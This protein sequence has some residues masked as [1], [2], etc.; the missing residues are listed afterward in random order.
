MKRVRI[1]RPGPQREPSWR[2]ELPAGPR[3]PDV[4]QAKALA[5]AGRPGQGT[6]GHAART[7][8]GHGRPDYAR[9]ATGTGLAG[10]ARS[11][12]KQRDRGNHGNADR[13]GHLTAAPR[14][15]PAAEPYQ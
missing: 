6:A 1:H 10:S 4:V 9:P 15:L 11:H 8:G 12:R 14:P 3:D 7:A 2:Q 13:D 5:R